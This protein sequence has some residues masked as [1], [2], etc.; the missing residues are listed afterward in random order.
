MDKGWMK[1]PRSTVEYSQGVKWFIDFAFA[2][3]SSEHNLILCP[4]KTCRNAYWLG[5]E[6]VYDHLISV[7]FMHGYTSWIH[8][9][10]GIPS[11]DLGHASRSQCEDGSV[12][13]ELDLMLAEGF[14]MY[15]TQILGEDKGLDEE[16]DGDAEAYCKLVNDGSQQ[17]YPGCQ[18]FSKLQ[19]LL[20]LLNI[21]NLWG[22]SNS[23]FDDLLSLIKDALPN[24]I[25]KLRSACG[26]C[27]PWPRHDVTPLDGSTVENSKVA[28]AASTIASI[29]RASLAQKSST[30][31]DD[32]KN[33]G[34]LDSKRKKRA[35]NATKQN[36]T[37]EPRKVAKPMTAPSPHLQKPTT[38]LCI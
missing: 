30:S 12:S 36:N 33:Q 13:D 37:Q 8:H 19:F 18:K 32:A 4:C 6:E 23:C 1:A 26:R 21:K 9:G 5:K 7:G 2:Q 22:V 11:S 17:L 38:T 34:V 29:K 35:S 15:D 31:L 14:G 24:A 28:S 25:S 20:R 16:L 27:I 3:S 10:E